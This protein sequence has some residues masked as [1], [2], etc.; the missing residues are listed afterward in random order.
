MAAQPRPF[1]CSVTSDIAPLPIVERS[2]PLVEEP[3]PIGKLG[4]PV[5]EE[6]LPVVERPIPLVAEPLPIDKLGIPVVEGP[7][8][9]VELSFPLVEEPLPIG[10]LGIPVVKEPLPIV[11]LLIPL[12]AEPLPIDKLGIPLVAEPLPIDKLGIPVVEEPLP[13]VERPIPVVAE[14][15]TIVEPAIFGTGFGS[16]VPAGI[17]AW[18]LPS[19]PPF[20]DRP[21]RPQGPQAVEDTPR[22]A[23]PGG[24]DIISGTSP[25]Q[26]DGH[27]LQAKPSASLPGRVPAGATHPSC[28]GR[29]WQ[30]WHSWPVALHRRRSSRGSGWAGMGATPP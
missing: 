15:L 2:I 23:S 7:L 19:A 21:G 5:V 3:L 1:F 24:G 12:V 4:I 27:T 30:G 20:L 18:H 28:R 16:P 13:V 22:G 10:K 6:P 8:P 9:V 17:S 26:S 25:S 11:E 29:R 14:P